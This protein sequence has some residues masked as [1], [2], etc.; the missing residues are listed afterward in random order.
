MADIAAKLSALFGFTPV[1]I[2]ADRF[3]RLLVRS[4]T[5]LAILV[6]SGFLVMQAGNLWREW[7]MLQREVRASQLHAPVGYL[8]IS[9]IS[10]Y[11]EA[12]GEWFRDD[13]KLVLL[14]SR[15]EPN[16]GHK[17]FRFGSGQIDPT[18]IARPSRLFISRAVDYP[19]IETGPGRIW[20]RIP[21][22]S[23]VVGYTL[24]GQKCAYPLGVLRKVEV[25][26]DVVEGHPYLVDANP[27]P[28]VPASD[29]YSIYDATLDGHRVTMAATGYFLDSKPILNDRGTESLWSDIDGALVAVAGKNRGRRLNRVA[30]PVPVTWET[31]LSQKGTGRVVV[32]ADRTQGIPNE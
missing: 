21:S 6:A 16:V 1:G 24:E 19:L 4:A 5:L 30:H 13:G 22:E 14:W 2:A 23:L 11:A 20:N 18:R 17:W 27:L 25:I 29:G 3:I 28:F 7:S 12:P 15:W 10:S 32:G 8:N 26:N 31:W 9:P